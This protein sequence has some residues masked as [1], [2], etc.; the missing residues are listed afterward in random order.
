M[1]PEY[2]WGFKVFPSSD[3]FP[4]HVSNTSEFFD[5]IL[6]EETLKKVKNSVA[7]H[8]YSSKSSKFKIDK[9]N[10]SAYRILAE[11]NC[12]KV[13]AASEEIF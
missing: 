4:I 1:Q 11:Q 6:T 9:S 12:P 2:Y 5:E 3:F 8:M 10:P 13:F 7:V